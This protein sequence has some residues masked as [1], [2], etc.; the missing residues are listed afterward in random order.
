M[1]SQRTMLAQIIAEQLLEDV[2]DLQLLHDRGEL[3]AV[4]P[5]AG[6][7]IRIEAN[8]RAPANAGNAAVDG[9]TGAGAGARAGAG[10][11]AGVGAG[12]DVVCE[13]ARSV[14]EQECQTSC[15]R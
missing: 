3:R 9:D 5:Q 2:S 13:R 10:A 14:D 12:E 1:G 11:G 15:R 7:Y 6:L 8:L 4:F